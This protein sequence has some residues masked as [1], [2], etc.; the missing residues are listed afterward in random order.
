MHYDVSPTPLVLFFSTRHFV[1]FLTTVDDCSFII[2]T[3][4]IIIIVYYY[5]HYRY[6]DSSS[7][8]TDGF[9]FFFLS[10]PPRRS[11]K[12]IIYYLYYSVIL[13]SRFRPQV[14]ITYIENA[15]FRKVAFYHRHTSPSGLIKYKRH[16]RI[17]GTVCACFYIWESVW[18]TRIKIR[19]LFLRTH[20]A[21]KSIGFWWFPTVMSKRSSDKRFRSLGTDVNIFP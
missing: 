2:I 18:G 16:R 15:A 19:K 21:Y 10:P 14:F 11:E 5:Y 3:I 12:Y 17:H 1:L 8:I 9:I 4:T 13:L 20:T 6:Y 7:F